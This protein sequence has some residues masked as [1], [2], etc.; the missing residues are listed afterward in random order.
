M[1]EA[2]ENLD[3]GTVD[4]VITD[5][6]G[7]WRETLA[8]DNAER[9]ESLQAFETPDKFLESYDSLQNRDWRDEFAGDDAKFRT[10]LDRFK[11]AGDLANSYREAQQKIS[12][13][14]LNRHEFPTAPEDATEEDMKAFREQYGVPQEA[15][16]YLENLPD[17]LVIGDEDKA[18]AEQF[19]GA[20]HGVNAPP[21]YAH[22]LLSAYNDF[23]E[24]E[25]TSL[26]EMDRDQHQEME[27]ELRQEWGT[28]YRANVNLATALIKKTFGEE[29]AEFFM[30]ARGPDNR[31]IL[32]NKAI[33]E[34]W[35][36][37]A[38][39]TNP[40]DELTPQG[41]GT[42]QQTLETEIAEL[43]TYM[44]DERARYNKDEKAQE[45]LRYLYDLRIKAEAK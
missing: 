10:Q 42:P 5:D 30:N 26:V 11:S 2:A 15:S 24:G 16:G 14:E 31:G 36:T 45:R 23:V 37:L 35:A 20:L 4:N 44:R 32:N 27:D 17:G 34:G 12:S 3:I 18:I 41:A 29:G 39:Q 38:R 13:G 7:A 21:Q 33:L 1:A 28:S 19:M 40:L 8:G 25:Q 6:G 9:L 43:E 22:A